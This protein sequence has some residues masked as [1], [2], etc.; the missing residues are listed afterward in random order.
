[1]RRCSTSRRSSPPEPGGAVERGLRDG[2]HHLVA[3]LEGAVRVLAEQ[4]RG[5]GQVALRRAE[6]HLPV[7]DDGAQPDAAAAE[8]GDQEGGRPDQALHDHLLPDGVPQRFTE[9]GPESA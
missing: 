8:H 7:G 6:H 5:G 9:H 2:L 3:G 1:M 4:P